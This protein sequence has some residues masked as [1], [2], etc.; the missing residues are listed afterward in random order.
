MLKRSEHLKKSVILLIIFCMVMCFS[1]T[2]CGSEGS[3]EP[4]TEDQQTEQTEP[5]DSADNAEEQQAEDSQETPVT[6][7]PEIA[8]LTFES[9]LERDY[10]TQYNVYRYEGGYKYFHIVDGDDFF[11]VPEGGTV[12]EGLSEDV[13]VLQAPVKNIYLAATAQM[14]LFL[15][16]D[17]ADSVRM[18][19]LKQSGWTYEEPKKLMDEG[20]ILFAGKY[21]E[22]DYE[23]LLDE[24][25]DLAI[26]STM[27]YHSPEVKEMIEDIDIPVL[28]DRS[29]YESNPIGRVEWIK[30][31][32]ELIGKEEEAKAFFDDQMSKIESLKD[33]E[34]TGKTVAFFYITTDGK[35]NVRRGDDYIPAMIEMAGA[36]YIFKDVVS[37]TGHSTIPMTMEAFYDKAMDA[38]IIVYNASID[39]SVKTLDDLIAKDPIMSELKAVKDNNCWSTGSSMYQR[40]DIV[41]DLIMDFH[42]LFTEEDPEG[43]LQYLSKLD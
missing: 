7:A 30:F 12:P 43:K 27:I 38:D 16:M 11:L 31:Y 19:S 36:Q 40:T 20:K 15:S 25:C 5:A 41:G 3:E 34:N 24:E 39:G 13:T 9:E 29:S 14:A 17:G 33:L 18:T 10:A 23:M 2:G 21:S 42:T 35:A 28:V 26:E 32:A 4:A 22:P 6:E 1:M 37:D 8:G